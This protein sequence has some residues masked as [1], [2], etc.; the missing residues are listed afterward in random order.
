MRGPARATFGTQC[1]QV[2]V[3]APP[4]TRR[5]PRPSQKVSDGPP[6]FGRSR[7]RLGSPSDTSAITGSSIS[8]S[9]RS[10]CQATESRPSRYRL[11]P[12][13]SKTT[14]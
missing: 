5:S 9:I 8:F 3:V 13:E 7:N 2:R 1:S 10:A 14:P 4:V 11:K 6:P 12:A